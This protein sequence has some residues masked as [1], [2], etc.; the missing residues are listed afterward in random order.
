MLTNDAGGEAVCSSLEKCVLER[1]LGVHIAPK[2][3]LSAPERAAQGIQ[4]SDYA[5]S[6]YNRKSLSTMHVRVA[7]SCG[8]ERLLLKCDDGPGES[9]MAALQKTDPRSCDGDDDVA[10]EGSDGGRKD[11][12]DDCCNGWEEIPILARD[13]L[14]GELSFLRSATGDVEWLRCGTVLRHHPLAVSTSSRGKL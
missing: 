8:D 4:L 12:R 11:G 10:S 7:G 2:S 9:W 3:P 13:V 6:Y 14:A 1:V 5:G